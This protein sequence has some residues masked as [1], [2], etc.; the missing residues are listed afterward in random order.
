MAYGYL[1]SWERY[2][3]QLRLW[4]R[5]VQ[6]RLRSSTVLV[7]GVGGLGTVAY[8]YLALAGIGR[9]ILVDS[10][11]V[12][13]TNLNRQI[14][15]RDED[16]GKPKA[17]VAAERLKQANPDVTV[18]AY[19]SRMDENLAEKLVGKAD[20]VVDG[21]DNWP[22]RMML[23]RVCWKLGKPLVHAGIYGMYGQ[24]TTVVPGKTPCLRCI[25]P[26]VRDTQRPFPVVG[27]TPGI[28][29][30]IEAAEAVKLITGYGRTL[31]GRLLVV[32]LYS[33]EFSLLELKAEGCEKVCQA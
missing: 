5:E 1:G 18:E 31:A 26:S 22:S 28:L 2:D 29:G 17:L 16:V 8:L 24:A 6:E 19:T 23:D 20:V 4:G 30:L 25:F 32:D 14:L 27:F 33:M 3:R 21:L 13:P 10:E 9:L 11:T 15:Y 7:V 12:E